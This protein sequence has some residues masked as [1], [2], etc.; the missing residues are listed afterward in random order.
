MR[1]LISSN[2]EFFLHN[3]RSIRLEPMGIRISTPISTPN[4][5]PGSQSSTLAV[6]YMDIVYGNTIIPKSKV[7]SI[8]FTKTPVIDE[9][10]ITMKSN[11]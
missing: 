3:V 7:E 6:M 4:Q 11:A 9:V 8:E 5:E 10:V 2:T 1:H